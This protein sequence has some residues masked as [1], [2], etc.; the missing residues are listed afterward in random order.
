[1]MDNWM[2]M[3]YKDTAD[4]ISGMQVQKKG[5]PYY[6]F[7]NSAPRGE[8]RLYESVALFLIKGD[9]G[10]TKGIG[11]IAFDADYLRQQ[12]F[13]EMLDT[14]MSRNLTEGHT[15][16]NPAVMMV[17]VRSEYTPLAAASGW[18]GGAPEMERNLEG[19]FPGLTLAIKLRGTT[20]AALGP[21]SYT[22]LLFLT[23][24]VLA[25]LVVPCV[26]LPNAREAGVTVIG[27]TPVP[28]KV[29][30]RGLPV[31]AKATV[32]FPVWA[33]AAVGA[34]VAVM[35]QLE[36]AGTEAPQVPPATAKGAAVEMVRATAA[37]SLLSLIHI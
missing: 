21:V 33:A 29:S 10:D 5:A 6:F 18:D 14:V 35:V 23:V 13:P 19:A 25:A 22:H 31:P 27:E 26:T 20:L 7:H 1:M 8:K 12:F 36:E 17:R 3:Q 30:V 9:S 37:V 24:K 28:D 32:M 2:K 15:E 11:G 4:E 34:K 16:K